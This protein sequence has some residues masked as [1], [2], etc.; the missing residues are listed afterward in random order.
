MRRNKKPT[1][2]IKIVNVLL[3]SSIL[4]M[5]LMLFIITIENKQENLDL[6]TKSLIVNSKEST[7]LSKEIVEKKKSEV[8]YI[9]E[10]EEVE[11]I[12]PDLDYAIKLFE[13]RVNKG[14]NLFFKKPFNYKEGSYCIVSINLDNQTYKIK[15][16]SADAIYKR[17]F[18]LAMEKTMPI[19]RLT[20]NNINLKKEKLTITVITN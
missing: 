11:E 13:T 16:C 2:F 8:V 4:I 12:D 7:M 1:L 14:V 10:S 9:E 18:D 5:G 15:E 6:N 19:E 20:Y 17:A 3:L